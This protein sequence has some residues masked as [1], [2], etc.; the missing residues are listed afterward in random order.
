MYDEFGNY[1]GPDINGESEDED[2]I[3]GGRSNSSAEE[4]ES[5][6]VVR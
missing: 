2:G 5:S 6:E 1:I 3:R 4:D